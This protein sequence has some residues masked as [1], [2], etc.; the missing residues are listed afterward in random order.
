VV[1]HTMFHAGRITRKHAVSPT[2][3]VLELEVPSLSTFEPGQWLDF[4]APP[5]KWVG[6]FSIASCPK[7]LPKID[8][9]VKR[10]SHPPAAWVHQHSA[11]ETSVEVRVGGSC[12]LQDKAEIRP[13]VFCAAGIGISPILGQYREYQSR[14]CSAKTKMPTDFLYSVTTQDELVFGDELLEL[15]AKDTDGLDRLTLSLTKQSEWEN[16][17]T[18]DHPNVEFKTGRLVQSFLDNAPK[19]A[20]FYLCGPPAMLDNS[21]DQLV[22]RGIASSDIQCERWW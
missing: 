1:E 22:K 4:V 7:K 2:V 13:A 12:I 21:V 10:S 16:I 15:V 5:H 17:E 9:A 19:D 20:V 11:M 8:I 6:G 14:R 18:K 3:M